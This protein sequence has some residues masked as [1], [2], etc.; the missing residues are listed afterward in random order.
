MDAAAVNALQATLEVVTVAE[1][2]LAYAVAIVRA[3]RASRQVQTGASPRGVEALVK[4][5]RARAVIAGRDYVT[6]DDV[7]AVAVPGLAHRVVLRPELWIRGVDDVEVVEAILDE[8][9]TPATLPPE[10]PTGVIAGAAAD[11]GREDTLG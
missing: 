7:K 9:P 10:A 8:V 3:T 1:P 5:G 6:P 4:L 2:V 11:D